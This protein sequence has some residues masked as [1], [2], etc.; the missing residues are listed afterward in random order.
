MLIAQMMKERLHIC[1]RQ[2]N[3]TQ[4]IVI[5]SSLLLGEGGAVGLGHPLEQGG[6]RSLELAHKMTKDSANVWGFFSPELCNG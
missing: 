2:T 1:D 6:T 3:K 5:R 4:E